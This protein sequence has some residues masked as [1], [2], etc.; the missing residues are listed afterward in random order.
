[1]QQ[2][3]RGTG[4]AVRAGLEPLD[5]FHGDVVV[6][7]GDAPL[8]D[9]VF[10]RAL[11]E[12]HRTSGARATVAAAVLADPGHYGRVVRDADG[13]VRR[14][15]EARD[16]SA[17]ELLITEVNTGFYVVDAALLRA[18]VPRLQPTNAQGE[19]Y[20][21]DAVH[22]A[23]A[24]GV[25]VQAHVAADPEVMLAVNSRV[26]LAEVNAVMRRRLLERLMLAG[27]TVEDPDTT[28][29]DWG[30][31]VGRDTLIRANSHLLGRTTVGAASEIGPGSFLRDAFVGDRARVVSSHLY[32][33]V[34]GSG[35]SVGP[36]AYIRPNT[37][38]AEG[39]K[40]GTF[41]EIKNSRIGEGSKVPHLSYVGDAIVGKGTNIAAGNITANYDG[42]EKHATHIGD[43]VRTGSDTTIVA[44]VT[45][46][47][48]AF[49]AAG[50]VITED[51][52]PGALGDRPRQAA[53]HRRVRRAPGRA[54]SPRAGRRHL[55][56]SSFGR[57]LTKEGHVSDSSCCVIA[58]QKRLKL[59]SGRSNPALAEKIAEKLDLSLGGVLLKTF[60]N[61]EIYARYEE[62]VRGTD[63]FIVQ[64]PAD[65]INDEVLEL[66]IMIQAAKLASARRVTAVMP[67]FPYSRQDKKSAAREPI[68]ARLM[69]TLLEAAG[70]D[71][72]LSMDLHQGQIQGFFEIPVDHMTAVPMLADYFRYKDF[73]GCPLVAV[74]A[75]AG[76]VKLAKR[77]I[78]RLP[79]AGLAVLTKMRP[80]HN[81]A[82]TLHFIGDVQ[83]KIAIVVDDMIDTGG[84][85]TSAVET[86]YENGARE[87]YV[88][89]THGIF[90][91]P[92][93]ERIHQSP[94]KEVVVTDTVPVTLGPGDSKIRVLS[95]ADTL[96]RTIKNVFE[97]ESVSELFAGDNQLF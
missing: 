78:N 77:F 52:P 4:D 38:L 50:S 88:T 59:F 20:L 32:E 57:Q 86:L 17:D 15:V 93:F 65:H 80:E 67:Y 84:S 62:N 21:T 58:T 66:L 19:L 42:Y 43:G 25:P 91:G 44:P 89:A 28:F 37:V 69:A 75:D 79:G 1:M 48:G 72:V 23:L 35:C 11:V 63:L 6:L 82:E 61:G 12:A 64:S 73:G 74:S 76:G 5:D 30:V 81:R 94:V 39:A 22:L 55:I 40:A 10:L 53:E 27:V 95:V 34:V 7:V 46:G 24:D 68:T 60:A 26:E 2:E 45:I 13:G 41:V 90:S 97:D 14:I 96:A 8:V 18:V 87:V 85:I 49:T 54:P 31:E 3:R 51:V 83:D 9:G 56:E 16:A 33:C 92:A 70:A 36:F 29:V 71:R 47:D